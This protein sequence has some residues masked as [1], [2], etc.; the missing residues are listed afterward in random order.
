[1]LVYGA[2]S[3][4]LLLFG[5]LTS[6]IGL[7]LVLPWWAASSYAAWKDIFGVEVGAQ[8]DE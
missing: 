6:G 1:L 8:A 7:L 3:L 4:A 5:L 2:L